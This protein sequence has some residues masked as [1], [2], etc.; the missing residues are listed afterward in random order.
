MV[1]SNLNNAAN[2]VLD[3]RAQVSEDNTNLSIADHT[4]TELEQFEEYPK[5][6]IAIN[7]R[8]SISTILYRPQHT[9]YDAENQPSSSF[10]R[11]L[12][13]L[14]FIKYDLC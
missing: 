6:G 10:K 5:L 8:E 4:D 7:T 12:V 11:T 3:N 14:P 1:K 13:D 9:P 2:N